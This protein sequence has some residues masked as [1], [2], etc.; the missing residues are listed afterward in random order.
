MRLV[1]SLILIIVLTACIG[2]SSY[3][4]SSGLVRLCNDARIY[5]ERTG[6]VEGNGACGIS[7]AVTISEI[8][9]VRLNPSATLNCR[10]A[11]VL[12]DWIEDD[13]KRALRGTG[14]RLESVRVYA[15]YACRSRNSQSGARMSEHALGNAIDIGEFRLNNGTV[16]NVERDWGNGRAGDALERLHNSACGP[17]GTVLGPL[18]DRFHYNHFHFDTADNGNGAYCR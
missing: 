5:G 9:G 1:A 18:S 3:S 12:A 16:L 2:R 11:R 6:Q 8:A 10:S 15:S 17:F 13:A 4:P 7:R 14:G